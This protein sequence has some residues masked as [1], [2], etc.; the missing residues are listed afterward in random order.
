MQACNSIADLAA[1]DHYVA[2]LLYLCREEM[3]PQT[4]CFYFE[5]EVQES[6]S[7]ALAALLSV[8]DIA[9]ALS[10]VPEFEEFL[11]RKEEVALMQSWAELMGPAVKRYLR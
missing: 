7:R 9:P 11:D 5:A 1:N 10:M 4:Q 6:A 8:A 3:K 2:S